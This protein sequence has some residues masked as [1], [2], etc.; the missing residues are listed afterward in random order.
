M[1]KNLFFFEKA[2]EKLTSAASSFE[3]EFYY[4]GASTLYFSLFNLMQSILGEAP[5]GKWKH[6]GINKKFNAYCYEQSLF[7]RDT[8]RRYL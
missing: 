8:L 2:Q 3:H 6:I 7:D 5:Q 4:A 1:I